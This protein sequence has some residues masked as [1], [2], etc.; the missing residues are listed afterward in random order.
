M[1]T[2]AT[3]L[4]A[5]LTAPL[6]ALSIGML[7]SVPATAAGGEETPGEAHFVMLA[8]LSAPI[9][10]G[11]RTT[12]NLQVTLAVETSDTQL[13]AKLTGRMPMLRELLLA[14]VADFARLHAMVFAP[15]DASLLAAHL[16]ERLQAEAP[17]AH[18]RVI[19]LSARPQ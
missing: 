11:A 19:E 5:R 3:R 17:G 7:S 6:L 2:K 8:P 15:V 1:A 10:D 18:V 4:A 9:V 16:D 14:G 13:A 12:G